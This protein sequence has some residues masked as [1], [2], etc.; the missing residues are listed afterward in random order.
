MSSKFGTINWKD[1]LT[2]LIIAVGIAVVSSIVQA[3]QAG[4][5]KSIDW[6]VILERAVTVGGGAV[7]ALLST[8]SEGT[9]L[10]TE[11]ETR[12]HKQNSL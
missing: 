4:G 2:S 6:M 10:A 5:I 12:E 3:V 8:N 1:F 9:P 11:S 7:L